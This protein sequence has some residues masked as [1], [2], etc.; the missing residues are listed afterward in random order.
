M[1]TLLLVLVLMCSGCAAGAATAGYAMKSGTSDSLAPQARISIVNE[2][3][4]WVREN[5]VK[6]GEK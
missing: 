1:K 6:K 2:V 4:E 5:F 3:K